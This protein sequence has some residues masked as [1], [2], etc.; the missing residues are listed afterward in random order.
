MLLCPS[1]PAIVRVYVADGEL[2]LKL[3]DVALASADTSVGQYPP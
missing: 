1:P 2:S 3:R